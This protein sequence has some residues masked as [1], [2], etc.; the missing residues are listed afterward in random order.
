MLQYIDRGINMTAEDY[1]EMLAGLKKDLSYGNK[2]TVE[3]CDLKLIHSLATQTIKNIALTDR[4]H[5]LV[6]TKLLQY[7]TQFIETV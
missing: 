5:L 1:L 3:Q 2:F 6:K 4:Q 7:K